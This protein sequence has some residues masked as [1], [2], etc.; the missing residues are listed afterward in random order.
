MTQQQALNILKMGHNVFLTGSP[1]SGK[2]HTINEYVDYLR[3]CGIEPAITASTGI[4]A[5]HIGGLTIHSW[6][7]I[8]IKNSLDARDLKKIAT[9]KYIVKRVK[10]A[11]V[12]II[13][14]VSMLSPQTF[15]M[16]DK[17][18]KE[19]KENTEPFGGLQ[20]VVV[21]DFF[22]LPPIVKKQINDEAQ[23]T[24]LEESF[25][26]FAY[27]SLAWQKANLI[28]CYLTEQHRQDDA[29]FLD[30]LSAIRR[31]EFNDTHLAHINARKVN[32]DAVL[33][34]TPKLFS[35]NVDVDRVN[36]GILDKINSE[37]R[38]FPMAYQGP[39]PLVAFLKKSCL[40]PENL[41]LK[42]G[43]FVMFTKNNQKEGFVN[44]T[45]G[46]VEAFD[47]NTNEPV[48]K[49][50][51]GRNIKAQVMD[52]TIEENGKVRARITQLPLRLAW[53]I[54]VHKSQG[55]SLDEAVMDLSQVFEF[56]QGYVALSR[57][58]RLSGLH[59]IGFNENAFKVHP[60]VLKKDGEFQ[61]ES[62]QA[63]FTFGNISKNEFKRMNEV[64]IQ[65]CGG[66]IMLEN[67]IERVSKAPKGFEQIRTT[68]TNAYLPWNKDQDIELKE[69]FTK[70][71][72]IAELAV[73]FNRTRGSINS[74]LKKL[75]L[76]EN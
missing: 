40:S 2:T 65:F 24:L 11:K 42:V 5:T 30:L 71:L 43:A 26:R 49:I 15:S 76:L 52:W 53:A 8:G 18:C 35:H 4:S 37:T 12:L 63:V 51:N 14:E 57:V 28:V 64:F 45:L 29:N 46:T 62:E 61:S 32:H 34:S 41:C 23:M 25:G 3:S 60:E 50:R 39:E 6:S 48:I 36:S 58:R 31:N 1:G 13:D 17:V 10:P 69:L 54:T 68:H 9:T 20:I 55:M 70:D 73:A 72:N 22:Q 47:K 16:I 33:Q 19:I 56:G 59:L 74:R 75:G 27:E 7:G 38:E 67:V 44:G 21:G 66:K